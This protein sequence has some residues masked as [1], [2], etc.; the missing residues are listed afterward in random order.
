VQLAAKSSY[1]IYTIAATA[2]RVPADAVQ[3][4]WAVELQGNRQHLLLALLLL[5]ATRYD[6]LFMLLISLLFCSK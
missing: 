4:G 2:S 5:M 3:H 6:C 1:V